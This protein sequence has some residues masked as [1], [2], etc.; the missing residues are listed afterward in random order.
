MSVEHYVVCHERKEAFDLGNMH[1]YDIDLSKH[2]DDINV[3]AD[4][5]SMSNAGF[6]GRKPE[7]YE[8]GYAMGRRLWHW[9]QQRDWKV[10]LKNDTEAGYSEWNEYRRID[11]D[12][13]LNY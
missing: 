7:I 8:F 11:L 4:M 6:W 9:C 13:K 2:H 10:E 12:G 5:V 3:F 1:W